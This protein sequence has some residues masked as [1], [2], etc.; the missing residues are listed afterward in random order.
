MS[1][2]KKVIVTND[3]MWGLVWF[4]ATVGAAI[5]F[6]QQATGFGEGIMAIIKAL[7]WPAMIMYK[8]LQMLQL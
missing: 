3:G 7:I 8:V 5:Y 6:M 1:S 2:D 4:L